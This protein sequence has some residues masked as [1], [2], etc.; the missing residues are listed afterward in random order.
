MIEEFRAF[1]K[2]GGRIGVSKSQLKLVPGQF[3]LRRVSA[4]KGSCEQ[5][6]WIAPTPPPPPPSEASKEND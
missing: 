1:V 6:K 5:I 3:E 4:S 2:D